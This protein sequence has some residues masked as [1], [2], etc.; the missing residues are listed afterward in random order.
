MNAAE[1]QE[2]KTA[3]ALLQEGLKGLT[4][5]FEGHEL[6]QNGSLDKI[7]KK[8]DDIGKLLSGRPSWGVAIALG[9]MGSALCSLVVGI[10]V[11]SLK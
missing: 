3:V 11:H 5:D 9:I 10:V 7:W 2:L 1:E 6:K 8:L 4:K